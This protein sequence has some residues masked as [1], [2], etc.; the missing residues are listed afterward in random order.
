MRNSKYG[1]TVRKYSN[2]YVQYKNNDY[3]RH[4]RQSAAVNRPKLSPNRTKN[5]H[6]SLKTC[7][8]SLKMCVFRTF[9]IKKQGF[10]TFRR[11][12]NTIIFAKIIAKLE[13]EPLSCFLKIRKLLRINRIIIFAVFGI[14]LAF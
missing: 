5:G 7:V 2:L 14:R 12:K 13:R 4:F 11:P 1:T 8:F 9:L 10:L 3:N 6:F